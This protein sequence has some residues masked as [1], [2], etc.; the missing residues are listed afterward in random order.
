LRRDGEIHENIHMV[1][2]KLQKPPSETQLWRAFRNGDEP[3]PEDV[4]ARIIR[5]LQRYRR[6]WPNGQELL[7]LNWAIDVLAF[8]LKKRNKALTP[9]QVYWGW[10]RIEKVAEEIS[11]LSLSIDIKLSRWA[12]G[13][14]WAA[15][16]RAEQAKDEARST[17]HCTFCWHTAMRNVRGWPFCRNHLPNRPEGRRLRYLAKRLGNGDLKRGII[18]YRNRLVEMQQRIGAATRNGSETFSLEQATA[19]DNVKNPW[20]KIGAGI[21][22]LFGPHFLYV[23]YMA[24]NE[25]MAEFKS[26]EVECKRAAARKGG[27]QNRKFTTN[28]LRRAMKMLEHGKPVREIEAV[29]DVSRSTLSRRGAEM[30]KSLSRS[31]D[32][33]GNKFR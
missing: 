20:W 13:L 2:D 22:S 31:E 5:A 32:K 23:R 26:A 8:L 21:R 25:L 15:A 24:T 6:K 10:K 1:W 3:G 9:K 29:T 12:E 30:S 4:A 14:V 28:G 27:S 18:N 7:Q 16:C 11:A 17:Q 33:I 19:L